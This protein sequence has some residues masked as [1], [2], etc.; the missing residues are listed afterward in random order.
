MLYV[1]SHS[2]CLESRN[3]FFFFFLRN[4]KTQLAYIGSAAKLLICFFSSVTCSVETQIWL[5]PLSQAAWFERV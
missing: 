2:S 1:Q 5:F 3:Y 4:T